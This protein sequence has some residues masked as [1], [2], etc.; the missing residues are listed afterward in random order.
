[1]GREKRHFGNKSHNIMTKRLR[2][3]IK[4]SKIQKKVDIKTKMAEN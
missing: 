1:M 4:S 3:R 2:M